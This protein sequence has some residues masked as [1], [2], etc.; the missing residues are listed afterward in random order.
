MRTKRLFVENRKWR[1]FIRIVSDTEKAAR[2]ME[3]PR[4]TRETVFLS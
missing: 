3:K 1:V 2:N 4:R